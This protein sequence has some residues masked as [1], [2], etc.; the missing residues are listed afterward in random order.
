M[1]KRSRKQ[2]VIPSDSLLSTFKAP[3]NE[4]R[5]ELVAGL[6]EQHPDGPLTTY[7]SDLKIMATPCEPTVIAAAPAAG[8]VPGRGP[9]RMPR[10]QRWVPTGILAKKDE[11][12]VP[13]APP[14]QYQKKVVVEVQ[15]EP[16]EEEAFL[17]EGTPL[18]T[19]AGVELPES[20]VGPALEFLEFCAAF[21]KPL[22]M[23]KAE[24]E[25]AL[26]EA[27]KGCN[28]KKGNQCQVV[29][30]H[31]RLL[32]VI[33]YETDEP[34]HIAVG[35]KS[36]NSW[37]E[38]L[39]NYLFKKAHP[40]VKSA[41]V[42]DTEG[43]ESVTKETEAECSSKASPSLSD[44]VAS[45]SNSTS[46]PVQESLLKLVKSLESGAD[47][48]ESLAV[49]EKLQLLNLLC[50]DVLSTAVLRGHIER[51]MSEYDENR[52]EERER[53]RAAKKKAKLDQ[54][55]QKESMLT[56]GKS[57]GAQTLEQES[58]KMAKLRSDT[59]RSSTSEPSTS[60]EPGSE[61]TLRSDAVKTEAVLW[62]N[63]SRA[64]WKLKGGNDRTALALQDLRYVEGI[65]KEKW[66]VYSDKDKEVLATYLN[67]K[68]NG[69]RR[70]SKRYKLKTLE[71]HPMSSVD[72]GTDA[73]ETDKADIKQDLDAD[74]NI[75]STSSDD[76][77][78]DQESE[79]EAEAEPEE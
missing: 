67:Q 22:G 32:S 68:K 41:Q 51:V 11:V 74:R 43:E 57:N 6:L 10:R 60:K 48:Y 71:S 61:E 25:K 5:C 72:A 77:G 54:E 2:G 46:S 44:S 38:V 34:K 3:G 73:M 30:V 12:I 24:A 28:L 7:P 52:R 31:V 78:S 37:L 33:L 75:T 20:A 66:T 65:P 63:G 8:V 79:A 29:Q 4:L 13:V 62:E 17:P 26:H 15:D 55:K 59:L 69:R 9:M 16:E 14:P 19:V 47:G 64:L 70:A 40:N 50:N 56:G 53:S 49:E 18:L 23:K 27:V 42:K 39:K 45:P 76:S 36:K 35:V 58:E 21:Y 1:Y